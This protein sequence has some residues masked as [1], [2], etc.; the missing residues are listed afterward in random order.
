MSLSCARITVTC[1][2]IVVCVVFSQCQDLFIVNRY[3]PDEYYCITNSSNALS[4]VDEDTSQDIHFK[5]SRFIPS[6]TEKNLWSVSCNSKNDQSPLG[7]NCETALSG[8]V[9]LDRRW[10]DLQEYKTDYNEESNDNMSNVKLFINIPITLEEN[11]TLPLSIR[12]KENAHIYLCDGKDPPNSN[13]YWISIGTGALKKTILQKCSSSQGASDKKENCFKQRA[14]FANE[15]LNSAYWTHFRLFKTAKTLLFTYE[16]NGK[17]KEIFS[18][19]NEDNKI[20]STTNLIIS[21]TNFVGRWKFHQITYYKTTKAQNDT[22]FGSPL[23]PIG[24]SVCIS[25]FIN[26]CESCQ[27]TF[28]LTNQENRILIKKT[29]GYEKDWREIRFNTDEIKDIVTLLVST[30]ITTKEE[31]Q[32]Q[33]WAL[34]NM[35]QCHRDGFRMISLDKSASC[36]LLSESGSI[37]VTRNKINDVSA[38]CRINSVG[39]SCMPCSWFLNDKCGQLK[40]CEK[41]NNAISCSC[42]AGYTTSNSL[43][44]DSECADGSYGHQCKKKCDVRCKSNNCSHLNGR[45][46]TWCANKNETCNIWFVEPPRLKNASYV[47]A[48]VEVSNNELIGDECADCTYILQYKEVEGNKRQWHTAL[49]NNT[50]LKT[51]SIKIKELKPGTDYYVRYFIVKGKNTNAFD[52]NIPKTN[53]STLC[54]EIQ[55]EDLSIDPSN[56]SITLSTPT[57]KNPMTC[58]LKK[59]SIEKL[60]SN[61]RIEARINESDTPI[62]ILGDLYPYTSYNVQ[63]SPKLKLSLMTGEGVPDIVQELKVVNKSDTS[64][65]LLW[66]RPSRLNGPVENYVVYYQTGLRLGCE[67]DNPKGNLSEKFERNTTKPT[68]ILENLVP[69]THYMFTVYAVNTKFESKRVTYWDST[70][71]SHSIKEEECPKLKQIKPDNRSVQT[72]FSS[73]DC[74]KIEG[75]ISI[76]ISAIC[77]EEWC[78]IKNVTNIFNYTTEN[79]ASTISSNIYPFSKYHLTVKCCRNDCIYI[80]KHKEFKTTVEPPYKVKDFLVFSKNE[81]TIS[82]RWRQPYPPTGILDHYNISYYIT[83]ESEGKSEIVTHSPCKL[84][85]SFQCLTLS[86]LEADTKYFIQI[87][88]RNTGSK[89]YG[90]LIE[91]EATTKTEASKP[92]HNLIVDWTLQNDLQLMWFHPNESNGYITHFNISVLSGNQNENKIVNIFKV[93]SHNLTYTHTINQRK[94]QPS[95]YYNITIQAFNGV[96]G[97]PVSTQDLSPPAIPFFENEPKHSITNTTI[98]IEISKVKNNIKDF[99]LF[100]LIENDTTD[101]IIYPKELKQFEEKFHNQQSNFRILYSSTNI[102]SPLTFMIGKTNQTFQNKSTSHL[103]FPLKTENSYNISILLINTYKDKSSYKFYSFHIPKLLKPLVLPAVSTDLSLLSL[104]F[105]LLIIPLGIVVFIKRDT[106]KQKL[107]SLIQRNNTANMEV[108]EDQTP[109]QRLDNNQNIYTKKIK[110]S[111]LQKYIKESLKNDELERQHKFFPRGQTKPWDCGSSP[112]NKNKNRYTNLLPYDHTR[113]VL[114]KIQGEEHSDYIN[115]NYIDGYNMPKAYIATQGPKKNTIGDFWRMVWQ[116]N[117]RHIV[118]LANLYENEKKKV[119]KYWPEMGENLRYG[120][121][122]LQY[123]SNRVYADYEH[124]VFKVTNGNSTREVQQYHFQSWPD[125]GVPLYAQ[126]LIPFLENLQKIPLST[127]SPIVVHCSAGV[128]RTGTIILCDSC[129]RMAVSEKCVDVLG[130]L[131]KI[132]NQRPNMVDNVEQYKL[133]HLVILDY[134]DGIRT[135]IPCSEIGEVEELLKSDEL[136]KQMRYLET[137]AWQDEIFMPTVL[138]NETSFV[139][140]KKNRFQNIIPGNHRYIFLPRYPIDD[141]SSI[142]INAVTV[143]GF[144]HPDRFIV[145]QQPLPNT[146]GDF[147]RLVHDKD[148]SVII[149]LNEIDLNYTTCN[150]WP[151]EDNKELNPVDFLTLKHAKT[152]I[153]DTYDVITVHMHDQN[154][155]DQKVIEIL[156]LK[157]WPA[158]NSC[159]DKIDSFLTFWE[160]SYATSRQSGQVIVTCFDGALASGLYVSMSFILEKI[161]LEQVCDVCQAVRIVR[162]NRKQFVEK[163]EQFIFLYKAAMTYIGGFEIYANFN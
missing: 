17:S 102:Q 113:V 58:N 74:D 88:A 89:N 116:E 37:S 86:N 76:E 48:V 46:T 49:E 139:V 129:L 69:F 134:L 64:V 27:I 126:T 117:V 87:R 101:T 54:K 150:F 14:V 143:D 22:P 85:I 124:R 136:K 93:V 128:G 142:Y 56:T 99:K 43:K 4:W 40:I 154:N 10:E 109:L 7:W 45:C 33:F 110:V 106:I 77:E 29:Y 103:D 39:K 82:V 25:V 23:K 161:K 55:R 98:T 72:Q 152:L 145:T 44:C 112:S 80:E 104:L 81:S 9:I 118:M 5:A 2:I 53:F 132:R 3:K 52:E 75:S 147:W 94:F 13:C 36:Q 108:S 60:N 32:N 140:K 90:Q 120:T 131:Q 137:T 133:A 114:K 42:S 20:F 41:Y 15:N 122:T 47:E 105:L 61:F 144:K 138:Q 162:H 34:D 153:C 8:T 111:E 59:S 30:H 21:S 12:I 16:N 97:H 84:W 78:M 70:T 1:L 156:A 107:N 159:P 65:H 155:T 67:K 73:I 62:I 35:K 141:E 19:C 163:E 125:H 100:L 92:P 151:S 127:K 91:E 24:D 157:N 121:I 6:P 26:M 63:I 95:T 149:S 71:E 31:N 146:L 96:N 50:F 68:I 51:Q 158:M 38:N 66:K 119:E 18:C 148:I 123:F 79:T 160:E 83:K 135:G 57:K 130:T 11:F 115:A 28:K